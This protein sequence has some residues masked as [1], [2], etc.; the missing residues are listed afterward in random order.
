MVIVQEK[1]VKIIMDSR[2]RN[3]SLINVLESKGM[4]IEIKSVHVGDYIVSDRVCIERKTI[5]DFESSII[6]GRLFDQVRRLKD[7]YEFPILILEG[8]A[9]YFRLKNNAINGAI[10]SLYIDYGIEV[11]CTSNAR[12]TAEIISR[13]AEHEQILHEREPSAKGGARAYTQNQFQQH[14]IANIPGIGSK[15]ARALLRHFGSI[16]SIAGAAPEDLIKVEK[17]GKKK[18]ELIYRTLNCAYED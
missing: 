17:I 12:N 11:L 15:L 4:C 10:A 5:A 7:N 14:I 8:E 1:G 13:I 3:G 6:N 9:E 16:K 2:E 18:A